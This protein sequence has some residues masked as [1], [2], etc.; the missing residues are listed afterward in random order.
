MKSL[1]PRDTWR[2]T[3]LNI[4]SLSRLMMRPGG[5]L[6]TKV[7][8]YQHRDPHVKDKTVSRPSY[9]QHGNSHTR[10]R[11]SLYWDGAQD[12]HRQ[13]YDTTH[14]PLCIL[15]RHFIGY[16]EAC[17][18]VVSLWIGVDI[19]FSVG[20]IVDWYCLAHAI[21]KSWINRWLSARL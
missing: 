5:R 1:I 11:R 10:G 2:K 14:A 4:W 21:V 20:L 6:N 3:F 7:S 15:D 13:N 8:S 17:Y 12:T 18:D 9:L 16:I 19:V